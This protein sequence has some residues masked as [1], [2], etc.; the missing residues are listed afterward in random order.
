MPLYHAL[1]PVYSCMSDPVTTNMY[2][3]DERTVWIGRF[4]CF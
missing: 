3:F 1:L 2:Q 4:P